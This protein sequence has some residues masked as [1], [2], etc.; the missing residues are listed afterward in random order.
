MKGM[1]L[2]NRLGNMCLLEKRLNRDIQNSPFDV[3]KAAYEQSSYYYAKKIAQENSKWDESCIIRM[4][5]EMAKAAV[6]IW[7]MR[8]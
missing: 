7:R 8:N 1:R 5:A 6:S 4:Q 3:K 2:V